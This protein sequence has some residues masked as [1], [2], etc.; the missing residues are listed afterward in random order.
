MKWNDITMF[1][2]KENIHSTTYISDA[3]LDFVKC[4]DLEKEYGMI[5]DIIKSYKQMIMLKNEFNPIEMFIMDR[6]GELKQIWFEYKK[7]EQGCCLYI[8]INC[9]GKYRE[10]ERRRKT[11]NYV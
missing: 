5:L 8:D 3:I 1:V 2:K 10:Y 4:G 7:T 11:F 9:S 6:K